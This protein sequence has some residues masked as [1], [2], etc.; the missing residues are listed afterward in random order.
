MGG[1]PDA[2]STSS[3]TEKPD[4]VESAWTARATE[5]DNIAKG[6]N[7]T[8]SSRRSKTKRAGPL[9]NLVTAIPQVRLAK[10]IDT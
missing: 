9:V 5:T 7:L 4:E 10:I 3:T 8:I 2:G 1:R 6:A